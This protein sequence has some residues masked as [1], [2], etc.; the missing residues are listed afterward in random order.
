MK[1]CWCH[2]QKDR[3]HYIIWIPR[4]VFVQLLLRDIFSENWSKMTLNRC[5]C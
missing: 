2:E 3:M 1:K 5:C 4:D